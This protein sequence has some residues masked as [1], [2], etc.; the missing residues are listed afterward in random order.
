[1][2]VSDEEGSEFAFQSMV[3][4]AAQV[5]ALDHCLG[6][7]TTALDEV[8]GKNEYKLA[9]LGLRGF[10]LGEHGRVGIDDD[11]PYSESRQIPL[12]IRPAGDRQHRR[13]SRL[14]TSSSFPEILLGDTPDVTTEPAA[15]VLQSPSG[16]ALQDDAWRLIIPHAAPAELYSKPDD[17][18]EMNDVAIRYP[19]V[20][21]EMEKRLRESKK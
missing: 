12:L 3:R 7:V 21:E 8:L 4:Y 11:R 13:N 9:V 17:R 16:R 20:V 6:V 19:H 10:A 14:L 18:W 15:I 2:G 1:M 5:I